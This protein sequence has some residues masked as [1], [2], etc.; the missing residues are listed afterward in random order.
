MLPRAEH[1]RNHGPGSLYVIHNPAW[2]GFV[3]IGRARNVSERLRTYQTA[4]PHRDYVLHYYR[5]FPDVLAAE[6]ALSN[7]YKGYKSNGEWHHIHA[8]D[9]ASLLDLVAAHLRRR[10]A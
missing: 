6:R 7:L 4:S 8:D 2:P 9:A 5:V 3:K 10:R 1:R